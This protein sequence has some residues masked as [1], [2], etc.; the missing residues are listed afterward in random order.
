MTAPG[1]CSEVLQLEGW[2]CN[3][4]LMSHPPRPPPTYLHWLLCSAV[5]HREELLK[6]SLIKPYVYYSYIYIFYENTWGIWFVLSNIKCLMSY[7]NSCVNRSL[8]SLLKLWALGISIT[9]FLLYK[10]P[11]WVV[12]KISVYLLGYSP[13]YVFLHIFLPTYSKIKWRPKSPWLLAICGKIIWIQYLKYADMYAG[14]WWWHW[15][16]S[17]FP[18]SCE[19]FSLLNRSLI[20]LVKEER[21]FF[22]S[23][24]FFPFS[25]IRR[26]FSLPLQCPVV[27]FDKFIFLSCSFCCHHLWPLSLSY[28]MLI[29][30][31]WSLNELAVQWIFV[32]YLIVREVIIILSFFACVCLWS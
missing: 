18:A 2:Y 31:N 27:L 16:D 4:C 8:F 29:S 13:V 17:R 12:C 19:P 26:L 32:H 20:L 23:L 10:Q 3:L 22:I 1:P 14:R 30:R 15:G 11:D 24:L 9:S 7:V 6:I 28:L 21:W 25:H 5:E